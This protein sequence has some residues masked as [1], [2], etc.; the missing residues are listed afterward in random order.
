MGPGF[1]EVAINHHQQRSN[2][3]PQTLIIIL[4]PCDNLSS[5]RTQFPI[6]PTQTRRTRQVD[7]CQDQVLTDLKHC[8]LVLCCHMTVMSLLVVITVTVMAA[9]LQF[10]LGA[11]S[12]HNRPHVVHP[13]VA[14]PLLTVESRFTISTACPPVSESLRVCTVYMCIFYLF[15]PWCFLLLHL[16]CVSVLWLL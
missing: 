16:H 13:P 5:T 15:V 7:S 12:D 3:R 1:R 6:G 4:A 8:S 11:E 2:Q 10:Q 9:H 14:D